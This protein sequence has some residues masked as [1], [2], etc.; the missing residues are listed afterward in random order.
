MKRTAPNKRTLLYSFQ[1]VVTGTDL[2][3]RRIPKMA[4]ETGVAGPRVWLTACIHGD[5]IGG[6]VL[7]HEL[8]KVL[9][10]V[11]H[12]GSVMAFP[13]VNPFGFEQATR[14]LPYSKEDLNRLF[15]G[16]EKG[17]PGQRIA[18]MVY[19]TIV[20]DCPTVVLDIHNDWIRSIP[21]TLLDRSYT[22]MHKSRLKTDLNEYARHLGFPVVVDTEAISGSLSGTLI[23]EGIPALTLEVGESYSVNETMTAR[24]V[25]AILRLL[26]HLQMTETDV[27]V[28][29][30]PTHEDTLYYYQQNPLC[31]TSGIVRFLVK[32]GSFV[33]KGQKFARVYNAFG[34]IQE[35][36]HAAGEGLVLGR[37]DH[38]LSFPGLPIMAF[39]VGMDQHQQDLKHLDS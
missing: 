9:R 32:E 8:F 15:P 18:W 7:I 26:H 24:G 16:K 27:S 29:P 36:L 2:S 30:A 38:A 28:P 12:R 17:S 33:R 4:L 35:T 6:T 1:K 25:A 14:F 39:G 23:R 3:K 13:I 5:E 31:S 10:K 11:M 22:T 20:H 21:Y 34:K 37:A 19:E